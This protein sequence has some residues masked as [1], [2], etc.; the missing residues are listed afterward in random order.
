MRIY[1]RLDEAIRGQIRC[2]KDFRDIF[3]GAEADLEKIRKLN[4]DCQ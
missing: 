2:D 3:R 1:R 4:I